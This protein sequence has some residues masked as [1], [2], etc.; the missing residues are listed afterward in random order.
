MPERLSLV[1][2]AAL[3]DIFSCTPD[4]LIEVTDNDE[5]DQASPRAVPAKARP[6]R[7]QVVPR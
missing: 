1:T 3:C 6:R 2:L 5:R 4:D 7:A